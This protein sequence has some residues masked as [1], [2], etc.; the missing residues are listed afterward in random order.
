MADNLTCPACGAAIEISGG[1]DQ[2]HC[3][4]CGTELRIDQGLGESRLRPT[5][6]PELQP[7][8]LA[9]WTEQPLSEEVEKA[10]FE[11]PAVPDLVSPG[12]EPSVDIPPEAPVGIG[13]LPEKLPFQAGSLPVGERGSG[14][15][16]RWWI[17][18]V[19]AAGI[20]LCV[21]CACIVGA[22]VLAGSLFAY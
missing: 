13:A 4:F 21:L 2:V 1:R 9:E 3:D 14:A 8:G 22:V 11:D 5:S 6:Q 16:G 12:E 20:L 10:S 17:A 15:G 7:G 19:V 18:I